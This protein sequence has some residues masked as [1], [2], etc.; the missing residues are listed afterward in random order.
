[1]LPITDPVEANPQLTVDS[2]SNA[3]SVTSHF[4]STNMI[5]QDKFA[6]NPD[7]VSKV[8]IKFRGKIL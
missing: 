3:E 7:R 4:N 8:D 1:M 2:I 6:D 5:F